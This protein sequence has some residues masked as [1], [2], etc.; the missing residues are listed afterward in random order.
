MSGLPP[1]FEARLHANVGRMMFALRWIMAPFYVGL[2]VALLMLAVK[3]IQKIIAAVP[4]LLTQTGEDTIFTVLT[5]IDMSLVANL[6]V[7]VMF[8]GWE[9]FIG[10]FPAGDAKERLGWLASLNF[11]DIKLSN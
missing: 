5:L 1:D 9:N 6:V 10:R 7:I 2:I 11:G 8:A 3:F 4:V